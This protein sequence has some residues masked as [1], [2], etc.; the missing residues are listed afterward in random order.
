MKLL[1]IIKHEEVPELLAR[2][3]T[4]LEEQHFLAMSA[5][6]RR[7]FKKAVILRWVPD[8]SALQIVAIPPGEPKVVKDQLDRSIAIGL[9][10]DETADFARC[11]G[12]GRSPSVARALA[13]K[14]GDLP[15]FLHCNECRLIL[16]GRP[17]LEELRDAWNRICGAIAR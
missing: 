9:M 13:C 5:P 3:G 1:D 8:G 16:C 10:P 2:Y 14:P 15:F 7:K 4:V 6:E 11:Q 17:T 12:C